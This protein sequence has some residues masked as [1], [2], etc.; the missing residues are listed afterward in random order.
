MVVLAQAQEGLVALKAQRQVPQAV[1]VAL[2][3][4]VVVLDRLAQTV[5][6]RLMAVLAA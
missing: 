2:A 6:L 4:V 3:L 5:Q 1:L